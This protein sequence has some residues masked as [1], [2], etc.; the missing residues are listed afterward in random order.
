MSIVRA[1]RGQYIPRCGGV[2]SASAARG[3]G[4]A[5]LAPLT[6]RLGGAPCPSLRGW[7]G[8]RHSSR[9]VAGV[10]VLMIRAVA[11]C[12]SLAGLLS[13]AQAAP[14]RRISLSRAKRGNPQQQ[15]TLSQRAALVVQS[16]RREHRSTLLGLPRLA[17][18]Y[19]TPVADEQPILNDCSARPTS[20]TE[21]LA[22]Q[23]S[24]R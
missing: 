14:E 17:Q 4:C 12:S 11:G 3:L 10:P 6:L 8:L 20:F 9:A 22:S 13:L 7:K 5:P 2:A 19:R 24:L 16:T 1:S 15:G 23:S 21:G 18:K